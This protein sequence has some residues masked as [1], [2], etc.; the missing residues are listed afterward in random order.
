M[1]NEFWMGIFLS[2]PVGLATSL[3]TPWF[4]RKLDQRSQQRALVETKNAQVEY[5]RIRFYKENPSELT[6]YL[7]HVAI[8]T[9]FIGALLAIISG[10]SYTLAQLLDATSIGYD[11]MSSGRFAQHML[12]VIGQ[13]SSLVGSIMIINICRPALTT[14]TKTKNFSEYENSLQSQGVINVDSG[15]QA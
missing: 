9:T 1:S 2:I 4:Q 10:V 7:V 5:E 3:A 12:Y 13:F 15:S 8:K 11:G 6:Q 14:W